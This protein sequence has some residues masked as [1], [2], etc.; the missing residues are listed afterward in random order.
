MMNN[1]LDIAIKENNEW[2]KKF[3]GILIHIFYHLKMKNTALYGQYLANEYLISCELN[4]KFY[5]NILDIF[6]KGSF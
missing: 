1:I 5:A 4:E 3:G 2:L 6:I